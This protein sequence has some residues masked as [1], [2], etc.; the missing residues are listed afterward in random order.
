MQVRVSVNGV[1]STVRGRG[2]TTA[3]MGLLGQACGPAPHRVSAHPLP[4]GKG[5]FQTEEKAGLKALHTS[6]ISGDNASQHSGAKAP[7]PI[8]VALPNPRESECR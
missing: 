7:T 8:R 5:C 6:L 1:A 3:A 4:P 2:C